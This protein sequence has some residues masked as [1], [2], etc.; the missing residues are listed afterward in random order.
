LTPKEKHAK[1]EVINNEYLNSV[2]QIMGLAKA[3]EWNQVRYS[4]GKRNIE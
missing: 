2:I 1:W 4:Q 3:K